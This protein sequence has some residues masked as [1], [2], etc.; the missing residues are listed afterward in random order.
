MAALSA[1]S[2]LPSEAHAVLARE[3][4]DSIEQ[5]ASGSLPE[6]SLS[7]SGRRTDGRFAE[8][9][10]YLL[11]ALNCAVFGWMAFSGVSVRTPTAPDL[12]R[13]G[14]NSTFL[15]LHG[16]WYRLLAAT[17]VHVGWIH[18]ATN[19]WCLWNLGLLAEPLV[20][21]VGLLAIYILTG[22]AGNLVSMAANVWSRSDAVG[23]GASGAVFGIAGVLIVMLSNRKLPIPWNELRPLRTSVVIFAVMSL[24]V[25]GVAT[26]LNLIQI[27]NFAH[28]GGCFSGLALGFALTPRMTA[29]RERY[30]ARQ[31]LTFAVT[32][33]AL[34]LFGYWIVKF[35][36][37]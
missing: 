15:V 14:A 17:F 33:L 23:A 16:E 5:P 1:N 22:I 18:L 7:S 10:T 21:P 36:Q 37:S 2:E 28:I 8:R 11:I 4:D 32:A 3:S 29:G 27:D 20:G 35:N 6:R 24:V 30:F 19:M 25:G 9:G 13:F 31:K 34:S 12:L 26:R